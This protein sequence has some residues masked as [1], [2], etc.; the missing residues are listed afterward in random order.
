MRYVRYVYRERTFSC[1][2]P[3]G[4]ASHCATKFYPLCLMWCSALQS[5]TLCTNVLWKTIIFS[6]SYIQHVSKLGGQLLLHCRT[7]KER[8][9][10]LGRHCCPTH[11]AQASCTWCNLVSK[12]CASWHMSEHHDGTH[13]HHDGTHPRHDGTHPHD[14]T[15]LLTLIKHMCKQWI[16]GSLIPSPSP[17]PRKIRAG[18][19]L[20]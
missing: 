10:M 16:P 12:A 20:W 15:W 17:L 8:D 2:C 18:S 14:S 7:A 19:D 3:L 13:P 5:H 1:G 6:Y 4:L 11:T 9:C